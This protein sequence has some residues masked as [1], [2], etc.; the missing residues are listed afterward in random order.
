MD[1]PTYAVIVGSGSYIPTRRIRNE[2][3]LEHAFYDQDGTRL[4]KINAEIIRQFGRITGI[5]E[6]G[7]LNA[8]FYCR[9]T[10]SIAMAVSL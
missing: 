9:S 2:D 4:K 7:T 3:F 1:H 10:N 6:G 8:D 5:Q